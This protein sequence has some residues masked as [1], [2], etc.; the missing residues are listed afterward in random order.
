MSISSIMMSIPYCCLIF[1]EFFVNEQSYLVSEVQAASFMH[2]HNF[3]CGF[4]C[5]S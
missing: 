5:M 3:L 4:P 2:G 1:C